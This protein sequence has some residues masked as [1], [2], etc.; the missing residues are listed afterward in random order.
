MS[1]PVYVIGHKNPDTDSIVSAI[2]YA[3][4]LTKKGVNALAGRLGS[5]PEDTE[6]LLERFGFDYPERIYTAKSSITDIDID[7][8]ASV[9]KTLRMKEALDKVNNLK[10]RGLSITDKQG[11]LEGIVTQDCLTFMW[12]KTDE[13]LVDIIGSI[14]LDDAAEILEGT[15]VLRGKTPLSGSIYLF[16]ELSSDVEKGSIVL[17]RNEN[18]KLLHALS[19]EAAMVIVVTSSPISDDVLYTAKSV[20]ASIITTQLSPLA[21][22]RLIYL[23]PTVE[24]VM[25]PADKVV[26]FSIDDP[27][28]EVGKITAQSRYRAYPVLDRDGKV[29]GSISRYHLLTAEKKKFVLVDHNEFKQTIDD[30]EE[31]EIVEIIDHHRLGG[32]ETDS[33]INI[34]VAAVGATATLISEKYGENNI[35]I[36]PNLAGLLLGA[37]TADTM[38]FHSPTTTAR[39]LKQKEI[40][41]EI[42]GVKSEDLSQGMIYVSPS[43]LSKRYIE[44]VYDDFKEFQINGFKVGLSQNICKTGDEYEALKSELSSYLEDACKSGGYD[45]MICML[46]NPNGSGSYLISAGPRKKMIENLFPQEK[47]FVKDLV[48]RKKQLLPAVISSLS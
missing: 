45:L 7:P 9:S 36:S 10:N 37:I 6:Y 48:S 47:G 13:E 15:I 18:D 28:E 43:I 1:R 5:V 30:I 21:V 11:H 33:V 19:A 24:Q 35:E 46:T 4:F 17:L 41:E 32:F 26:C 39:D 2:A 14:Q 25:V 40:L 42:S 29:V 27:L 44:I 3:E 8:S 34:S 16:P 23:A 12:T 22:T 20:G 38:N 31:G